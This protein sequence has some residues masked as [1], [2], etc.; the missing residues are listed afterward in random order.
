M[1]HPQRTAWFLSF[2]TLA[3][4]EANAEFSIQPQPPP[5]SRW[6]LWT[7]LVAN[8]KTNWKSN[9]DKAFTRFGRVRISYQPSLQELYYK[10][11]LIGLNKIWGCGL[12]ILLILNRL[13]ES[14]N[15]IP[16]RFNIHS[17][18]SATP[19]TNHSFR[20][21]ANWISSEIPPLDDTVIGSWRNKRWR[22]GDVK[23]SREHKIIN[24]VEAIYQTGDPSGH[25][26][27]VSN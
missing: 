22:S 11:N 15:S 3:L 25:R 17:F 26:I 19:Y 21:S 10:D 2:V 9:G 4:L 12:F 8:S 7:F 20:Q 1:C 6:S 13:W 27:L 16:G 14:V 23:L 18:N 24:V 5:P